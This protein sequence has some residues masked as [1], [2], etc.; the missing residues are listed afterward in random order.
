MPLLPRLRRNQSTPDAEAP[1]DQDFLRDAA[2]MGKDR[3]AGYAL[4]EE[5]YDGERRYPVLDRA[6]QVLERHGVPFCENFIETVIDIAAQHIKVAGI[7]VGEN[8]EASDWLSGPVWRA[9]RM[10]QVQDTLHTMAMVKGDEFVIV[11]WDTDANLPRITRNRPEIVK[12]EYGDDGEMLYAAKVWDTRQRGEQN[13]D[14]DPILRMNLY[15]PERIEKYFAADGSDDAEWARWQDPDDGAWPVVWTMDGTP[16]GEPIGIPVVHYRNRPKGRDFGRSD[17]RG[18]MSFDAELSKQLIDLFYVM[19]LQGWPQRWASGIKSDDP[20]KVAPGEIMKASSEDAKFGQF[21]A[22]DPSNS[23]TVIEGTLRRWA[24]KTQTPIHLMLVGGQLPT[25]ETLKTAYA[26]L[27][28]KSE[29]RHDDFGGSHKDVQRLCLRLARAFGEPQ[30]EVSEDE[31]A[32]IDVHWEDAEPR[33]EIDEANAALLHEELGV[34]QTT[35]LR[36]L[37][38]DPD[39]EASLRAKEQPPAPPPPTDPHTPPP[40]AQPAG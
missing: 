34:S 33:N 18:M 32:D 7:Q 30:F 39:E 37:G 6:K 19:D 22:A 9:N 4:Y 12:P 29:D 17:V 13:P 31:E 20:L 10:E 21:D 2:D 27:V 38:Y 15:Y 23:Q 5:F 14:G 35:T 3:V 1:L 25:G 24:L 28:K 36:K 8:Q 16:D 11:G 26:G 40:Q